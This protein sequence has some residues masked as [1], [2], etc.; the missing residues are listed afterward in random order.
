MKCV[1]FSVTCQESQCLVYTEKCLL[2][3]DPNKSLSVSQ[4]R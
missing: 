1:W 4:V 3:R 2:V